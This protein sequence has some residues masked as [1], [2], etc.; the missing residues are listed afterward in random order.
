MARCCD[1]SGDEYLQSNIYTRTQTRVVQDM[2]KKPIYMYT[3][4]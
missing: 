1:M 4:N 2:A 3:W